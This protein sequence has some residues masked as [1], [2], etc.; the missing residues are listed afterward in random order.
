MTNAVP[1]IAGAPQDENLSLREKDLVFTYQVGLPQPL[2]LGPEAFLHAGVT[3]SPKTSFAIHKALLKNGVLREELP[4]IDTSAISKHFTHELA[5]IT[6][7]AQ[8]KL[9]DLLFFWEEEGFRWKKFAGER[10]EL[11]DVM[12]AEK[13]SGGTVGTYEKRL[14]EIEGLMKVMPSLRAE[15]AKQNEQLPEYEQS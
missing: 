1:N 2:F 6:S 4:A 7:H 9:I 10:Q 12:H 14:A 11:M 5:I 15:Q 3:A 8:K 13:E